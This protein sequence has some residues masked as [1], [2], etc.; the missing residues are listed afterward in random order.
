MK[1]HF[2]LALLATFAVVVG[3]LALQPS[4]D[5]PK[6]FTGKV[7]WTSL[8]TRDCRLQ[9]GE[10]AEQ[11]AHLSMSSGVGIAGGSTMEIL[12]RCRAAEV[13]TFGT[14]MAASGNHVP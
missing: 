9:R 13:R 1:R 3:A 4:T 8:R 11:I 6:P 7:A 10:H 14:S 12:I 2:R 5:P